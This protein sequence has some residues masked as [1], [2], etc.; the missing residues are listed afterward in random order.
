[1]KLLLL[2]E[3]VLMVSPKECFLFPKLC[4][5]SVIDG[6]SWCSTCCISLLTRQN[7]FS[8]ACW[9]KSLI[10][11]VSGS[12][13]PEILQRLRKESSLLRSD[14]RQ[15]PDQACAPYSSLASVVA[16]KTV[17]RAWPT[18]PWAFSILR[19]YSD[20]EQAAIVSVTCL[21]ADKLLHTWTPSATRLSTCLMPLTGSGGLGRFLLGAKMISIDFAGFNFKLFTFDQASMCSSSS[22]AESETADGTIRYVSS[23]YFISWLFV[24]TGC[25]SPAFTTNNKCGWPYSWPLTPQ[26]QR[27]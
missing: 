2:R 24:L 9:S 15:K 19:A 17:C 11:G 6:S 22:S 7:R 10:D 26:L 20:R 27:S 25:R 5:C 4:S 13:K 14:A 23:A 21:L 1:M 8:S 18:S 3:W 12:Q 16:W